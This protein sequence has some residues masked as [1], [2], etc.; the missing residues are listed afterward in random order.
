MLDHMHLMDSKVQELCQAIQR[1]GG[2]VCTE[3]L[4]ELDMGEFNEAEKAAADKRQSSLEEF[5]PSI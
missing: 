5:D 3:K 4:P 1:L 2:D